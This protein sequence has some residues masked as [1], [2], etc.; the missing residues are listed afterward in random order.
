MLI[1][2]LIIFI[3]I[4]VL[5][6]AV[7][8]LLGGFFGLMTI[9]VLIALVITTGTIVNGRVIDQKIEMYTEENKVIETQIETV[10]SKYME[11]ESNTLAEFK[12]DDAIALITLYPE[13][14]ADGLVN[15]QIEIYQ[16]NNAEIKNLKKSKINISN[17][18][19]WVYFG[20]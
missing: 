18:K 1:V 12:I 9:V 14:K 6:V 5:A 11:Y 10:V 20:K 3:I 2:L 13:L 19:W 4:T 8:E 17:A 16:A 15:A 7:D